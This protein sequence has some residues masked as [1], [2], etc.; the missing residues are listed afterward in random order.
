MI[1][2]RFLCRIH[3]SLPMS[4]MELEMYHQ[5]RN[6]L[7][8]D[9]AL[10]E[11]CLQIDA[12]TVVKADSA[13]RM[14]SAFIQDNRLIGVCGET[15]LSNAKA[16][17]VTMIQV[18]E[19]YI[20]HN[21]TKAFES[22]FGSVTCL[23]GCFSMYRIWTADTNKPLFVSREVV[24][25]YSVNRVDTLHMKN[26]LSLGEDRYL[27]TLLL[28]HHSKYKTKYIFTAHAWTVGPDTWKVFLSQRRRWI[29]ST[30]HNLVELIPL[31]QL[32][33]FCCFS[34]RFIVFIDLLSTVVQ[35]VLMGYI[36]YLLYLVATNI[37]MV[38][39]TCVIL[40][41]AIYG[42]QAVIFI[43]RR[44]WEMV[45]WMIVYIFATPV[46][47]FALPLYAFWNMDDFSWGNTRVVVGDQGQKLVISD[48]GKFDPSTIPKMKWDDYWAEQ[49]EMYQKTMAAAGTD[50][51]RDDKSVVSV[52]SYSKSVRSQKRDRPASR[53]TTNMAHR[54]A[55]QGMNVKSLR[56]SLVPST[57]S[58]LAGEEPIPVA[59]MLRQ[60]SAARST[61][62]GRGNGMN[63]SS[64]AS[65]A[66]STFSFAADEPLSV[67]QMIRQR[68]AAEAAETASIAGPASGPA[69]GLS[70]DPDNEPTDS[71]ILREIRDIMGTAESM[72]LTKK[73]VRL[74]LERRLGCKLDSRRDFINGAMEAILSG[75]V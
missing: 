42:L 4:P 46:F 55:G 13:T 72:R 45:G 19:Y 1:L 63:M 38:P 41:G 31:Q 61:K 54:G 24:E 66:P 26:L 65:I 29:N 40:L 7:G 27:T 20:S 11:Y 39:I 48:E 30:V 36:T 67:A 75:L 25:G 60:K 14:I 50:T 37:N 12:D 51:W 35:P 17:M 15:A 23:P 2:M 69:P 21:L 32:C 9:P 58:S 10:Y 34:M 71:Q 64:R 59:Q 57:Y 3:Y 44:K 52:K 56:V 6:V 18:Y 70:Y 74:E 49:W 5:I 8:V 28:K 73:N 16:S 43:A 62:S 33:G 68:K 47:S 22:L 53:L